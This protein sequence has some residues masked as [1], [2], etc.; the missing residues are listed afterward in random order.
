MPPEYA[1]GGC[2]S[3]KTDVFSFGVLILEIVNGK[4][5]NIYSDG[6]SRSILLSTVSMKI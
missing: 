1:M 6:G 4:R 5:A 3:L 2:F